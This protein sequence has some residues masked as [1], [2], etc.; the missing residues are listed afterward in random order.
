MKNKI[1]NKL[2]KF[3]KPK[4]PRISKTQKPVK[5]QKPNNLKAQIDQP[6]IGEEGASGSSR[7]LF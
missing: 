2:R 1:K 7:F 6:C 4:N 3:E 5:K